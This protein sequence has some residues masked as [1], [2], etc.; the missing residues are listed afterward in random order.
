MSSPILDGLRVI[1]CASGL[2]GSVAALLL[3][4]AGADVIKVE[5]RQGD[6]RRGSPAFAIWNRSKQSIALDLPADRAEFEIL[7]RGADV[8]IHDSMEPP[9]NP[10]SHP[11]LICCRISAL[12]D[13]LAEGQLPAEDMLVMAAMGILSEQP[14][15]NRK[16]PANLCFPLGSWCAAWLASIGITARLLAVR[17][18]QQ[19]GPVETSL[20]QGMMVSLMM[21]WRDATQPTASL[22]GRIDKKI[23]PSLFECSDGVWLHIMKNADDT[24][25]MK[26]LLEAMGLECVRAAN[27]EWPAHF[28]YNNWGANV[29][30]FRSRPSGEWLADLWAADIPVQP[31]LTMGELYAD[32]Q[33]VANNYVIE[34]EDPQFGKVRQPGFPVSIDP[35][36]QVKGPA[37][38]LDQDRAT[39]AASP[40]I[41]AAQSPPKASRAPLLA[42]IK[43]VDFG[44]YLAGP[45]ATMMLADLGAEVIKVEGLDGDP[46]RSNESAFMG[47]QRGKRSLALDIRNP[48]AVPVIERL[49]Q[50]ANVVHHNLRLPTAR[51]FG[52][53]Y[54]AL[55]AIRS[56]I[57]FGH[58]SAYGPKGERCYWPGYD[59][60]FQASTGWELANAGE[61]NRPAWLRFGMMDHLCAMSLA[62][63]ILLGLLKREATGEGSEVASSLLGASM[64]TLSEV[65]MREDGSL[66][67][68]SPGLDA[69]QLGKSPGNRIAQCSDGW[70]ALVGRDEDAPTTDDLAQMT[71]AQALAQLQAR[72]F[73]A[74]PLRENAG[75]DFLFAED[76]NAA[77]LV[78]RYPHP[79]YGELRHPGAFWNLP[80]SSLRLDR[81]PPALGQHSYEVL[82]ELGF[83]LAEVQRLAD[84]GVVG[85]ADRI[86]GV[87][88]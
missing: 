78:A 70:I 10:A 8:L 40:R 69:E 60:L 3:A 87:A 49:V 2:S 38:K 79:V 9:T 50:G 22:D 86:K 47:C 4:E 53:G 56:D 25:L 55:K 35:P 72:G 39:I 7:L 23:L 18:G 64:L 14:A 26:G 36:G 62:F 17:R 76:K 29:L 54:E 12:P 33:A 5:P 59:Q 73:A 67:G 66:I 20:F 28:R 88:A 43:V 80:G 82:T 27:A 1:D 51:K 30:A 45:L 15:T 32:A 48:A 58:V 77:G 6:P 74:V 84:S 46:M 52:L 63:G 61:G 13:G 57:V 44:Q 24:P 41:R 81:A 85:L 16:G 31:A 37:P 83:G 19:A 11:H 42:G 71:C 21:L 34:I 68:T 75:R 65:M